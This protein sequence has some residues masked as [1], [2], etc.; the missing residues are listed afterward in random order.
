MIIIRKN[1][2]PSGAY[3]APQTVDMEDLPNGYAVIADAVDMADFYAHNGFVALTIEAVEHT[4]QVEQVVTIE[5]TR[6]VEKIRTVEKT[7]EVEATCVDENGEEQTTLVPETYYEE[8]VYTEDETYY[9]DE[10]QLADET[11]TIDTMTAYTPNVE[12]WE[13]WKAS[14]PA[15]KEPEPT[16]QDQIE[17]QVAYTAMMT[18]TL[19]EE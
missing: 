16:W 14:L 18:D 10:V 5:K 1:P 7:R 15:P 19:L 3:P 11:Y 9:E 8:E 12:A 13:A 17:A 4:R 2:N 6:Q